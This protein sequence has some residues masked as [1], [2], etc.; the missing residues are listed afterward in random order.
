MKSYIGTPN[1]ALSDFNAPDSIQGHPFYASCRKG[2]SYGRHT[3][4]LNANSKHIWEPNCIF[5]FDFECLKDQ[6]RGHSKCHK[7]AD[8]SLGNVS[9]LHTI[10]R[11]L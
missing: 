6:C 11:K 3:L 10:N 8:A 4:L 7:L 9:L 5:R 1:L 2:Q